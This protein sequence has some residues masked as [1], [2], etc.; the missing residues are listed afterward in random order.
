MTVNGTFFSVEELQGMY[1]GAFFRVP[2]YAL[3]VGGSNLIVVSF[4]N[5]Y[6][7]DGTGLHSYTDPVDNK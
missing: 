2:A 1:Q 5:Q 4:S 6:E 3:N 7:N